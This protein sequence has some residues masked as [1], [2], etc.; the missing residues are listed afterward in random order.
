MAIMKL[1]VVV[2]G[3]MMVVTMTCKSTL[4]GLIRNLSK[5]DDNGPFVFVLV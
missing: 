1:A 3:V 4:P 2:F 5:G